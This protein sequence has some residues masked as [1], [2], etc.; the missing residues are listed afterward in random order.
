MNGVNYFFSAVYQKLKDKRPD[1]TPYFNLIV[2]LIFI[3]ALHYSQLAVDLKHRYGILSY[4]NSTFLLFVFA[5]PISIVLYY[6]ISAILPVESLTEIEI[7]KKHKNVC[8]YTFSFY[9]YLNIAVLFYLLILTL[10][11]Q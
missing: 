3:L 4:S 11:K 5:I 7:D 6:L 1:G 8:Y 9:L 2:G 10:P